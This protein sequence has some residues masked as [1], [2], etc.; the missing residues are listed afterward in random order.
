M[1]VGDIS[2]VGCVECQADFTTSAE[3]D[4]IHVPRCPRCGT[5]VEGFEYALDQRQRSSYARDE[6]KKIKRELSS[7]IHK[8][9]YPPVH[10]ASSLSVLDETTQSL[11]QLSKYAAEKNEELND[12]DRDESDLDKD[13]N[14]FDEEESP[15]D[16]WE[17]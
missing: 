12:L 6:L 16:D 7:I 11:K 17:F 14:I 1:K 5:V 13:L 3:V 9:E 10:E 8:I 4:T 15:F 2:T